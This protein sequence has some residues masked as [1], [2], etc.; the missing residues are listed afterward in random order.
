[1]D[2]INNLLGSNGLD[3]HLISLGYKTLTKCW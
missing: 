1:L 3:S 2:D